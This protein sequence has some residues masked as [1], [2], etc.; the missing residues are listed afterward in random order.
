VSHFGNAPLIQGRYQTF[1]RANVTPANLRQVAYRK[2][3]GPIVPALIV[4]GAP[5][6]QRQQQQ[7][8]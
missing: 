4:T 2:R 6:P 3:P 1:Y 7:R 5:R 8:A